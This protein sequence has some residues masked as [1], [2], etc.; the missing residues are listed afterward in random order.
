LQFG[1]TIS[2]AVFLS[3][4]ESLTIT[5]M[6]CASF[7]HHGERTTKLGKS[8]EEMM[9]LIVSKYD[10]SLRWTLG[11]RWKVL[12]ISLIVVVISFG[13]VKFLNKEMVPPQDQ[14]LFLIRMT[15]P[16][17]SSMEYTDSEAKKAEKWLREQPELNSIYVAIGG[18]GGGASDA[19]SAVMFVTLKEKNLRKLSQFD[20]M[21]K[22]RKELS[23]DP[24]VKFF[25]QDLSAR[26]FGGGRGYPIEF[27]VL[28]PNWEKLAA[29]ST[30][31]MEEMKN[32]G[33]MTDVDTNYLLGMPEIQIVPDRIQA[34]LHGV[35][36]TS[37]GETVGAL[38][39]G[40]KVGQ[41]P[42]D[43]HRD[44]IFLKVENQ[45]DSK[46]EIKEL[47]I[48]NTRSNL[49][50]IT[51]VTENKETASLQQISRFNRQRAISIYANLA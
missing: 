27:N 32:S 50:P 20:F 34:A 10:Q 28:G 18:F 36:I 23:K 29:E 4:I 46:Q 8:F 1:V 9:R 39:G 48:G 35:S 17:G 21:N 22:A 16:V 47:L 43:G 2:L 24:K 26:G 11:H 15:L 38:I 31:L 6:R 37:I 13:S 30:K 44:D 45:K 51:R 19:N 25:M 7:V 40:I 33:L 14:S 42:K 41:Y 3:L 5:P 12:L 49:I